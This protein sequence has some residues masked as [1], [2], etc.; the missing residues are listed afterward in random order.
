MGY[1]NYFYIAE[2]EKVDNF[3]SLSHEE[4][5]KITAE[6]EKKGYSDQEFAK[7]IAQEYLKENVLSDWNVRKCISAQEIHECGKYFDSETSEK[8]KEGCKDYSDGDTEFC[9][10][11]PEALLICAEHYKQKTID[12]WENIAKS[13]DMTDEEIKN[14]WK[15]YP[16]GRPNIKEK[17]E[18]HIRDLKD[19]RINV[20]DTDINNKFSI[21]TSWTYEYTMFEL[22]H[23]YKSIDWNQY[24]LIWCGY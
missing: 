15:N 11:K 8:I 19:K 21:T 22:I 5:M 7:K 20:L 12:W 16:G 17:L 6:I 18:Y 2:K 3:F 10:V 4:Q 1:R 13:I 23:L 14:D 9:I 24:Q